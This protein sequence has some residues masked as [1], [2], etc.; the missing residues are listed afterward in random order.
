M[1]LYD[2]NKSIFKQ[3]NVFDREKFEKIMNTTVKEYIETKENKYF[4]LLNRENADYTIFSFKSKS[5]K[6]N[7]TIHL[8]LVEFSECL[9]NRGNIKA[10]DLTKDKVA[11]EIWIGEDCYYFFPY[12]EGVIEL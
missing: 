11:L 5:I 8:F 4:M 3:L 2:L 10:I 7:E 6:D 12:D 9:L 1:T